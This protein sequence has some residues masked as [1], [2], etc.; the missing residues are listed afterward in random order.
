MEFQ[1]FLGIAVPFLGTAL[2][3]ALVFF[4]K[5]ISPRLSSELGGF[6]GGVMVAASVF[7][8]LIPAMEWSAGLGVISFLPASVGFI[9]GVGFFLLIDFFAFRVGCLGRIFGKAGA[10]GKNAM[11]TL[12][13]S[14]HNLPEGV[15]VGVVYAWLLSGT[16]DVSAASALALSVGVG[17]QNFPE[18]AIISL[19]AKAAGV[20][21]PR[22]FFMGIISA[23]VEALGALITIALTS[24]FLPI[25]PYLLGFAAGAMIYVVIKELIPDA[26]VCGYTSEA[27][28]SFSLGFLIMM[29]LDVA[30]G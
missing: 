29:V 28:L 3:A 8:L 15:A 30:L 11:L 13:V 5:N 12:A 24:V 21:R 6:A 9:L 18:G 27:T 14:V 22:A 1:A 17:V 7:S 19:P 23:V 2:G 16:G 20:S 26:T 10:L 25:L 4:T